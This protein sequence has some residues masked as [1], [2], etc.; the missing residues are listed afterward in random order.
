MDFL[1]QLLAMTFPNAAGTVPAFLSGGMYPNAA[2][3]PYGTLLGRPIMVS[4]HMEPL[5][6]TGDVLFADL[7][8]Y[9]TA[10][11]GGVRA[12]VSIHVRFD[13]GETAFRFDFR[14]DGQ[15]WLTAPITPAA[16]GDTLSPFVAL[17][18]RD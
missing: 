8:M 2:S 13:Y 15:P 10:T 1:P 18:T 16:G 14:V 3:A 17:G 5:G 12:A 7:G 4:E 6:T 11:R 9:K